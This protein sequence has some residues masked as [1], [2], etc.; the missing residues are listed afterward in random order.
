MTS[1]G[2]LNSRLQSVSSLNKDNK[3]FDNPVS[4]LTQQIQAHLSS[5][6][7][8]REA[9]MNET[10]MFDEKRFEYVNYELILELRSLD[11]LRVNGDRLDA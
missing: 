7:D 6:D 8:T 5:L 9:T 2:P 11:R 1:H 4:R 10:Q 3:E